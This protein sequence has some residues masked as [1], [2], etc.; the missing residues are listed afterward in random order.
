MRRWSWFTAG[1]LLGVIAAFAA[2]AGL[3]L[4]VGEDL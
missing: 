3:I 2:S 4:W 1:A